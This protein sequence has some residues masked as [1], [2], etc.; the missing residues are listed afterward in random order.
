MQIEAII[1]RE[2]YAHGIKTYPEES[3]GI[4]SGPSDD[5]DRLVAV[6]RI[7]NLMDRYNAINPK[8][9]PLTARKGYRMDMLAY[10][11]LEEQLNKESQIIR[12][13]YHAHAD[14]GAYFS[15]E[16]KAKA[17]LDGQPIFPN[18]HYLVLSIKNRKPDGA[19]L[20]TFNKETGDFDTEKVE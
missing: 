5:A 14:A 19:V 2:C 15:E 3:C 18:V 20:A 12:V 1:L 11:R 17:L 9:F 13:I 7:P 8:A 10:Q 4:I 6:H 16:D